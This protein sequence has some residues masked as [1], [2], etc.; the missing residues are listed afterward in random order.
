MVDI[1]TDYY[2][3]KEGIDGD[4]DIDNANEADTAITSSSW[5]MTN[6]RAIILSGVFANF[7]AVFVAF[8]VREIKVDANAKQKPMTNSTSASSH[9]NDECPP[10]LGSRT[11][12]NSSAPN[13]SQFQ[14][15]K[16]SSYQILL[17]TMKTPNFRRFL[18]VC[19]LTINVRMIFRHM[20]G[21]LPKYMIR[22]FG[23]NTP[24]GRVYAINPALIIVLVPIVTA[25]T[26]AV[27]PL[28][29]IHYGTYVSALSVFFLAFSTS[30]PACVLFVIT[31]SIGEAI[32][33]PRLYDYTMSVA[34]EGREGTYMALSSAPLFLAKLPVGFLSGILLQR[35]CPEHLEEGEVRHSKT[36]WLIIGLT[37]IV[38]PIMFTL[39]WGYISGGAE[40]SARGNDIRVSNGER[41]MANNEGCVE[42]DSSEHSYQHRPLATQ[43]S[44]PRVRQTERPLV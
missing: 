43:I 34:Q 14:P 21:T 16:G 31:L 5:V 37:T 6:N 23:E 42:D 9:D 12:N 25:A 4:G 10:L 36:M 33:S 7:I 18:V 38:S 20:D 28:I 1:L 15:I 13:I 26:S 44:L 22:E 39:L 8:T 2:N 17:E 35:Y 40:G 41:L 11:V 27:D 30:L 29:M 19:L 32:W 3:G 24:K